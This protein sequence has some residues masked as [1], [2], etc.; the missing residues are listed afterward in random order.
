MSQVG[1]Q[2]NGMTHVHVHVRIDFFSIH[3]K[4]ITKLKD[5]PV[6]GPMTEKS[7]ILHVYFDWQDKSTDNN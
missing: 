2:I 1:T 3:Y 5:V 6:N 4:N 7:G